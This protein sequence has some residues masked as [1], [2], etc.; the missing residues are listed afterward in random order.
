LPSEAAQGR[1]VLG[2][3]TSGGWCC[4]ALM[5]DG[6]ILASCHEPMARGQGERLMPLLQD[7]LAAGGLQW[8]DLA[9]IGVG[10]GPGNFTGIRIS[11]AAA[12]GLALGLGVVAIGVT[13]FE[14][15]ALDGPDL[16][17]LVPAVRGQAWLAALG[18]AP[19]MVDPATLHGPLIAEPSDFPTLAALD[20]VP[21]AHPLAE[22]I[23]R[24]AATRLGTSQ[25]R[26]APLYL[27]AP[28]ATPSSAVAPALID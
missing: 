4:A 28:D 16:P 9:A 22:A 21:P 3:D 17:V 23:A 13:R 26:P 12:R 15:L 27:R 5:R 2:F 8:Q 6:A 14:A 18:Q 19:T 24:I 1:A 11:V 7:L 25:P 20:A 10:T